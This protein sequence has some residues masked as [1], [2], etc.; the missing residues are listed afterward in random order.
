[1][2]REHAS[3]F[4]PLVKAFGE[5]KTIQ[6]RDGQGHWLDINNPSF[7]NEPED[8]RVKPEATEIVRWVTAHNTDHSSDRVIVYTSVYEPQAVAHS[9]GAAKVK[10]TFEDGK[11][12]KAEVIE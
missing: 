6:Y 3:K 5:G 10:Y 8:Y 1:M 2:K 7:G 9:I 11:L 12:V 4:I